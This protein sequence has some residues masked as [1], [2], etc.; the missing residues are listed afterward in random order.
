MSPKA[1]EISDMVAMLPDAEQDLAYEMVKRLVLAWDPDFTKATPAER[2]H[3]KEAE[4]SGFV[5]E[6]EVDWN[7]LNK[8]A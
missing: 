3:M 4:K 6:D 7:N 8:Y 1:K 2:K 5:P